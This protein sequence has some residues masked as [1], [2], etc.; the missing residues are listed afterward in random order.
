MGF[1]LKKLAQQKGDFFR[2]FAKIKEILF[3]LAGQKIVISE[4]LESVDDE[5]ES[6]DE[7]RTVTEKIPASEKPARKKSR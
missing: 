6:E 3:V 1:S 2:R 4:V 5:S 7:T